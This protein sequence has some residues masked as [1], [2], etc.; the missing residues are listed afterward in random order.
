MPSPS[1]R[2]KCKQNN[3][4]HN[5]A[6]DYKSHH[7]EL[8]EDEV[9][10]YY[11][12]HKVDFKMIEHICDKV[13]ANYRYYKKFRRERIKDRL[14]E[15][16]ERKLI[17]E[18]KA[19][20]DAKTGPRYVVGYKGEN[21]QGL[22]YE[23][24]SRQ[25]DGTFTI[26][27]DIDG[28]EK[29]GLSIDKL[30]RKNAPHDIYNRAY[31]EKQEAAK[32]WIGRTNLMNCG[33]S[34]T[35]TDYEDSDCIIVTFEDGVIVKT[36]RHQFKEGSVRHP[37]MD[38]KEVKRK[39]LEQERLGMKVLN[40]DGHYMELIAYRGTYCDVKRDDGLIAYNKTWQN[41]KNG[42]ISFPISH[43]GEE[44]ISKSGLKATITDKVKDKSMY[45]V[46]FEDGY[47]AEKGRNLNALAKGEIGHPNIDIQ[48]GCNNFHGFTGKFAWKES[49]KVYYSVI[50]NCC[51]LREIYTPQQ[52]V[53]HKKSCTENRGD[54]ND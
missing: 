27:F 1:F 46:T 4:N 2:E 26:K 37:N 6:Y 51:G 19:L 23:I 54:K 10:D 40:S 41:F 14:S 47:V 25:E 31:F 3:I 45:I 48:K 8:S 32:K 30:S 52:M 15:E 24:I 13:G 21:N 9:I 43:I 16:D 39:A 29:S 33:L 17:L 50:C 12:N 49:D 7:P 11:L 34:A 35:V 36:S 20:E 28:F 38:T 53:E 22:A 5:T 44:Y 18:F 42:G